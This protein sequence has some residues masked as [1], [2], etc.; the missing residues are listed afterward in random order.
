[1]FFD[2]LFD[3]CFCCLHCFVCACF[4]LSVVGLLLIFSV[5]FALAFIP[6]LSSVGRVL[7]FMCLCVLLVCSVCFCVSLLFCFDVLNS[8]VFCVVSVVVAV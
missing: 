5:S 6:F 3:D 7:L 4:M 8:C 1:M 2:T